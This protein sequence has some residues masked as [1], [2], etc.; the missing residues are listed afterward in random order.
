MHLGGV[1][2]RPAQDVDY[3]PD[4]I[5]GFVGP[6]H[7]FHDGFVARF[8]TFQLFFGDEDIVGKR[9]VFRHQEGVG[10]GN[11]QRAYKGV[12][13][14]FQHLDDFAFGLAPAAFGIEGDAY[15]IV[16]HGVCRVTFGNEYRVASTF[17]DERVLSVALAL[18][19]AYHLYAVVVQLVLAFVHF[20]DVVVQ[21]QVAQNVLT[22][23]LQGMRSKVEL[24]EYV[25][26]GQYF[27]GFRMEKIHQC[28]HKLFLFHSLAGF[29]FFVLSHKFSFFMNVFCKVNK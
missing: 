11:F 4:G 20:G 19:G 9:T 27:V 8:P 25:F 1:V 17:G 6:F 15:F 2:A 18:E 26:Q 14:A 7:Y 22:K 28:A 16:V 10:T 13:G 23:H 29:L 12:V 24:F 5:L 21:Q 3:L